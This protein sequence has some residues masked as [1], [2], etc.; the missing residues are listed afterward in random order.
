[1]DVTGLS[2]RAEAKELAVE[3]AVDRAGAGGI[4]GL[5]VGLE[6]VGVWDVELRIDI[7]ST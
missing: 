5:D 1:M 3:F 4:G 6:F 2:L 7:L